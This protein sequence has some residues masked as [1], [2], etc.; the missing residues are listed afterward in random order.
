MHE[1]TA[2]WYYDLNAKPPNLYAKILTPKVI[3]LGG[4]GFWEVTRSQGAALMKEISMLIKEAPES[5]LAPSTM[6]G[7]GKKVPSVKASQAFTRN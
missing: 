3:I 1:N 5:C 2:T 6:G 7:Y 4:G